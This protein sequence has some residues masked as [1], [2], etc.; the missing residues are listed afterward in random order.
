MTRNGYQHM[1][2]DDYVR[3]V[4]ELRAERRAKLA[5]IRTQAQARA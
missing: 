5:A 1:V 4:R 2:L 3:R